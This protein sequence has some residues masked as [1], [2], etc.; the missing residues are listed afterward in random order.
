L[1]TGGEDGK[2]NLWPIHSVELEAD[3]EIDTDD[4]A[5]EDESMDIDMPSPKGRKRERARDNEPVCFPPNTLFYSILIGVICFIARQ[6]NQTLTGFRRF[7]HNI[8]F[9]FRSARMIASLV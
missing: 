9:T 3:G 1:V 8:Y 2:I 5:D 4:A 7:A 6:K